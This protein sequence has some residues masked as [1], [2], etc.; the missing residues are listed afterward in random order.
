MLTIRA[1]ILDNIEATLQT[2]EAFRAVGI[3]TYELLRKERPAA[4]VI[5]DEELTEHEPDDIHVERLRVAI[6]VVVDETH[7]EA[8]RELEEILGQVHVAMMADMSRGHVALETAKVGVKY[9]F[10]DQHY[11]RAGAD[12]NF[13]I[14]YSTEEKDP[15]QLTGIPFLA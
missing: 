9:L 6:R 10:L 12:M 14:L 13:M 11:P 1:R 8:G 3:G 5:P 2:I 15:S 4:G 7:R